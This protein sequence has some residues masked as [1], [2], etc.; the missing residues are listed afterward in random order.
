MI[1]LDSLTIRTV[2]TIDNILGFSK[3]EGSI[4]PQRKNPEQNVL[5][6]QKS[7]KRKGGKSSVKTKG[8]HC[9]FN[10]WTN[11]NDSVK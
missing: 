7:L 10:I 1:I 2:S 5:R 3:I 9:S 11:K 4:I 6:V 8:N